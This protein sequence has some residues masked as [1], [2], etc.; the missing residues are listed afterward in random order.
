MHNTVV[1]R[2]DNAGGGVMGNYFR[3]GVEPVS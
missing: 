2:R 3:E 1:G